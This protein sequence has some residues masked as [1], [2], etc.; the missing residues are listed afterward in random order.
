[1]IIVTI[2]PYRSGGTLDSDLLK[3]IQVR[4]PNTVAQR[5]ETD[6]GRFMLEISSQTSW[7]K[8]DFNF[9][10]DLVSKELL[11]SWARLGGPPG[12]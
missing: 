3:Q 8:E 1:M 11:T 9:F 4:Y 6:P 2:K 10:E 7:G 5:R 12:H